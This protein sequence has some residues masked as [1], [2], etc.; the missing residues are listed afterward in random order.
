[1][2]GGLSRKPRRKRRLQLLPGLQSRAS[3]NKYPSSSSSTR[4]RKCE[5]CL[6]HLHRKGLSEVSFAAVGDGA[7]RRERNFWDQE[8]EL[9]LYGLTLRISRACILWKPAGTRNCSGNKTA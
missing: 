8:V 1:M 5:A 7:N 6:L 3:S 2:C 4:R 9:M